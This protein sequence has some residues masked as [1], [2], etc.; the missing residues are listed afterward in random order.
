MSRQIMLSTSGKLL[1]AD[2]THPIPPQCQFHGRE[3]HDE[4]Q[5]LFLKLFGFAWALYRCIP[6]SILPRIGYSV[7]Q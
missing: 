1:I 7:V 6:I 4:W 5:G 3:E 2:E